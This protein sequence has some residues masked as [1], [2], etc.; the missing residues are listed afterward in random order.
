M[1]R[2]QTMKKLLFALLALTVVAAGCAITDYPVITDARGDYSGIIRTGHKAYIIPSGQVA[3]IWDD[4]TDELF[5][6]AFQNQY[7][8]QKIYTFNNFDPTSAVT[9]LDQTYCDWRYDGCQM[10]EAWN[11][12]NALIDDVFDYTYFPECSG[13][14]SLSLLVSY[15]SRI[16]EC[17]DRVGQFNSQAMAAEFANLSSTTWRGETAYVVPMNSSNLSVTLNKTASIPVVG[18]VNGILTEQLQLVVP[19]TANTRHSLRAL[20]DF[21]AQNG[22][23]VDVNLSYNSLSTNV[24]AA[25]VPNGIEY[26]LGRY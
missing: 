14:R 18:N 21:S 11:P 6:L 20:A 13:A 2:S 12:A 7:G 3:T 10:A 26:N 17:G 9:F 22:N 16:G 23:R 4:G 8:D 25:L 24:K 5:S 19:M 15:T 1:E